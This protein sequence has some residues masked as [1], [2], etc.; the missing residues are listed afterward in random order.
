M[1]YKVN[2]ISN[3]VIVLTWESGNNNID[4]AKMIITL[5]KKCICYS[6]SNSLMEALWICPFSYQL[7]EFRLLGPF[8]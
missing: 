3:Y 2:L 8:S 4:M 7:D 6:V 1:K 5:R